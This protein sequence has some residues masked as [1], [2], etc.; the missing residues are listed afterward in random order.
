MVALSP[1]FRRL[2]R[3]VPA[4]VL[5]LLVASCASGTSAA[6]SGSSAPPSPTRTVPVTSTPSTTVTTV[7]ATSPPPAPQPTSTSPGVPAAPP[8]FLC[9]AAEQPRDIADAYTG[10]LSSGQLAQATACVYPGT[11]PEATSRALLVTGVKGSTYTLDGSAS[12]GSVF[13]YDGRRG[14]LTVT[15]T[16]EPNGHYWV[17][18]VQRG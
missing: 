9:Q 6:L 14:R 12:S 10:A 17:T 8:Q 16:A 7:P 2:H 11:V 4:V 18:S 13:V 5:S 3:A 15:V 1:H